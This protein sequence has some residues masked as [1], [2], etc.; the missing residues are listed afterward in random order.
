MSGFQITDFKI[1]YFQIFIFV[2]ILYFVFTKLWVLV[3]YLFKNA[4]FGQNVGAI[5]SKNQQ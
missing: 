2:Q 3:H 1:L 4:C 5:G